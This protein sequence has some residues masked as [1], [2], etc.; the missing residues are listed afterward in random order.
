MGIIELYRVESNLYQY[1][2]P[3]ELL[4]QSDKEKRRRVMPIAFSEPK[5]LLLLKKHVRRPRAASSFRCCSYSSWLL[6]W[7]RTDLFEPFFGSEKAM[8]MTRRLFLLLH[9]GNT[10]DRPRARLK[11][12]S[13]CHRLV[14]R[15]RGCCAPLLPMCAGRF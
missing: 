8:G 11:L 2:W 13:T 14:I 7:L 3:K 9:R 5:K 6:P 12:D 10:A 1:H 15:M 4:R